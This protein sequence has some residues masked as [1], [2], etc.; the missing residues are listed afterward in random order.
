MAMEVVFYGGMRLS[1][2]SVTPFLQPIIHPNAGHKSP[3]RMTIFSANC[4]HSTHNLMI[5]TEPSL[6]VNR[7]IKRSACYKSVGG[8]MFHINK[9]KNNKDIFTNTHIGSYIKLFY[10]I[11]LYS[12][13]T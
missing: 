4:R 13:I 7:I 12:Y 5:G 10:F 1:C 2:V 9:H 8:A 6:P 3:L 11:S